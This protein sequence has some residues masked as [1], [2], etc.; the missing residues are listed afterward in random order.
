MR[1]L[2]LRRVIKEDKHMVDM[3][4]YPDS[5]NDSS[6]DTRVRSDRGSTPSTPRWVKV[7]GIIG[8]VLILLFIILHLTG[9]SFSGHGGHR[10]PSSVIEQGL[11]KL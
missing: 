11:K 5:N 7:F 9:N 8:L 4:P 6:D 10:P 3:R 1:K 2:L